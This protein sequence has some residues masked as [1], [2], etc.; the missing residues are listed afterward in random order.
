MKTNTLSVFF[1]QFILTFFNIF[2]NIHVRAVREK[3]EHSLFSTLPAIVMILLQ[4]CDVRTQAMWSFLLRMKSLILPAISALGKKG[5]QDFGKT[6]ISLLLWTQNKA[7]LHF[8]SMG[9]RENWQHRCGE[10]TPNSQSSNGR[11]TS[12]AT[13]ANITFKDQIQNPFNSVFLVW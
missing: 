13:L 3:L 7:Q 4:F 12:T 10:K 8:S 2:Y 5:S 11:Y 1:I 9:Q 6:S